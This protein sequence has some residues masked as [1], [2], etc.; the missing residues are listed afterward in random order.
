MVISS[1]PP[2]S[3]RTRLAA[4]VKRELEKETDRQYLQVFRSILRVPSRSS[5][6]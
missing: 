4:F 5:K 1:S 6:N 2:N 3:T